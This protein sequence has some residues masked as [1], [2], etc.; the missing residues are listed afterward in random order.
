MSSFSEEER[1]A[2]KSVSRFLGNKGHHHFNPRNY[3]FLFEKI[4]S[5]YRWKSGPL[6]GLFHQLIENKRRYTDLQLRCLGLQSVEEDAEIIE[7][8]TAQISADRTSKLQSELE[9]ILSWD[10]S[11][12]QEQKYIVKLQH[13]LC[14]LYSME[15]W[16]RNS[17][18]KGLVS[19]VRS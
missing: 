9:Q 15:N 5:V 17:A 10:C 6:A 3:K 16:E 19:D 7:L 13:Y 8:S 1:S 4:S 14:I 18:L 2:A 12:L 11:K